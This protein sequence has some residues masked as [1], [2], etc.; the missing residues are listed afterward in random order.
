MTYVLSVQIG[1]GNGNYI[2]LWKGLK[3]RTWIKSLC[4]YHVWISMQSLQRRCSQP[5]LM[6]SFQHHFTLP[7]LIL[8]I[9]TMMPVCWNVEMV[10]KH[11]DITDNILVIST[12]VNVVNTGGDKVM[13]FSV[14]SSVRAHDDCVTTGHLDRPYY[15]SCPSVG[16]SGHPPAC[17]IQAIFLVVE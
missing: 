2:P 13:T 1:N 3:Y 12:K 15:G 5:L 8:H 16:L 11:T 7:T 10:P 6:L 4:T 17:L 9:H 14:C